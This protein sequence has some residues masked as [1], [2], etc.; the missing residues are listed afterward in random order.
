MHLL[1]LLLRLLAIASALV[2][3]T[4]YIR[5]GNQLQATRIQLERSESDTQQLESA[6]A[7]AQQTE[8]ELRQRM[9]AMA[10]ELATHK[11]DLRLR[12]SE[13]LLV[14][15]E[16]DQARQ[17]LE[18][19][20]TDNASLAESNDALKREV[21]ELKAQGID[22]ARDPRQLTTQIESH[23]ARI[24]ALEAELDD[25]HTVLR[26]LFA[27]ANP[28][29]GSTPGEN[30]LRARIHQ[31]A[32]AEQLLVLE[33]G[34]RAG[35]REAAVLQLLHNE[36]SIATARVERVNAD[37]CVVHLQSIAADAFAKLQPGNEID[38]RY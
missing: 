17:S 35:I 4:F 9:D 12:E 32:A 11:R 7:Q 1:S 5:G 13:V 10:I 29:P 8:G 21:I 25:A 6:L 38:Y 22:P 24:R 14:R 3:A 30:A 33:V 36:E 16:L 34:T 18:Q 23:R 15:K 28:D 19:L 2:V 37:F 20:H 31:V 27:T 26:G